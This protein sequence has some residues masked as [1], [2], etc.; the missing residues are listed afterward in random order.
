MATRRTCSNCLLPM[1]LFSARLSATRRP[2]NT[3]SNVAGNK[4]PTNIV[5][6][7][8]GARGSDCCP[9]PIKSKAVTTPATTI[10]TALA[11]SR[12]FIDW[13]LPTRS[14][15]H[16]KRRRGAEGIDVSF[17][18]PFVAIKSLWH[19]LRCLKSTKLW[20]KCHVSR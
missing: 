20:S 17:V 11:I 5:A 12:N 13:P 10:I 14:A 6:D 15:S 19:S 3:R 18:S 9:C 16:S 4:L 1:L 2:N 8:A 7:A